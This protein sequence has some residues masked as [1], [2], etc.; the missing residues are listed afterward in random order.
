MVDDCFGRPTVEEIA[1]A[2]EAAAGGAGGGAEGQGGEGQGGEG[3]TVGDAG[4]AGEAGEG[5]RLA[6]ALLAELRKGSPTTLKARGSAQG[7]CEEQR[8]DTHIVL[9]APLSAPPFAPRSQRLSTTPPFTFF[10]FL[11]LPLSAQVGLAA[12]KAQKGKRLRD[13]LIADNRMAHRMLRGKDFHEARAQGPANASWT[14]KIFS[15]LYV[16]FV[17]DHEHFVRT[18]VGNYLP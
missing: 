12:F 6:A 18:S 15:D 5:R 11:P 3:A 17:R 16:D 8:G 9:S 4:E 2:L 13:A 7:A 10:S 1:A 14:G